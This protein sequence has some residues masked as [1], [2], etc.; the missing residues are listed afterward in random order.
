MWGTLELENQHGVPVTFK[1]HP[2]GG[3][4]DYND[5]YP[6]NETGKALTFWLAICRPILLLRHS[7]GAAAVRYF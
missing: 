2:K 5:T 4:M 6:I 7:S 3:K 1:W